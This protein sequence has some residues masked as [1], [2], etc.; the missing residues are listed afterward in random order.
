MEVPGYERLA[1]V[2]QRAYDQAAV[3]KGKER[4]AQGLPFHEQPMQRMSDLYG[5]GFTLGQA[6]KKSQE[7]QRLPHDRAITEL[8]G[9]INYLA[10]AV[11]YLERTKQPA[12]VVTVYPPEEATSFYQGGVNAPREVV[13]DVKVVPEDTELTAMRSFSTGRTKDLVAEIRK[14]P[15]RATYAEYT[16]LKTTFVA[17]GPADGARASVLYGDDPDATGRYVMMDEYAEVYGG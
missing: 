11:V 1:D 7:S 12:T 4:H 13:V 17:G 3:G 14:F 2:L 15:R 6:A 5:V 16:A 8:L 9:A 10:G